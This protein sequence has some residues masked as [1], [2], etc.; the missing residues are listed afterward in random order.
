MKLA[1]E[2]SRW[3]YRHQ[4]GE[5]TAHYRADEVI[6]LL[7]IYDGQW[8]EAYQKI[9]DNLMKLK[10]QTLHSA[11]NEVSGVQILRRSPK[12]LTRPLGPVNGQG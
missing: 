6:K 10:E 12:P 2:L 11:K 9:G 8:R 1:V 3:R 5:R 4:Q 7:Q